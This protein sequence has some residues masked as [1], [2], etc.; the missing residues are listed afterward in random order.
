[1]SYASIAVGVVSAATAIGGAIGKNKARRRMNKLIDQRT[2]Y[3]TPEEILLIEKALRAKA[4]TG[5]GSETLAYLTGNA[6]IAFS[7]A[8]GSSGRLGGD[9]NDLAALFGLR[10]QQSMAIGAENHAK[11]MENFSKWITS[12]NVLGE[13]KAAE[14]QSKED[15]L[16]DRLQAESGNYQA[17]QQTMVSGINSLIGA[18]S[19]YAMGRLYNTDGNNRTA[20]YFGDT[21]PIATYDPINYDTRIINPPSTITPRTG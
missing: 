11:Q 12:L 19:S 17:A 4:S 2:S 7:G 14:W 20:S 3:K 15:I 5:L 8:I 9:P 1:M 21:T 13:N 18:G 6:D 10:M 16:K